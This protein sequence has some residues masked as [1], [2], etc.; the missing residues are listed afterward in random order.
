MLGC[1]EHVRPRG[2]DPDLNSWHSIEAPSCTARFGKD[3]PLQRLQAVLTGGFSYEVEAMNQQY[4]VP[5]VAERLLKFLQQ[6]DNRHALVTGVAGS[7]KTS[8]LAYVAEQLK[9]GGAVVGVISAMDEP[10]VDGL[11]ARIA[12]AL[13][14]DKS[15]AFSDVRAV[16]ASLDLRPMLQQ[17]RK[18][19]SPV[20]L[21]IDDLE[22]VQEL[23]SLASLLE[24]L[25]VEAQGVLRVVLA[26]RPI[27][28]V[29]RLQRS[30]I[31]DSFELSELGLDEAK[32]LLQRA[33]GE[34]IPPDALSQIL[35][36]AN[37]NP[38]FLQLFAEAVK[39]SGTADVVDRL[40][41]GAPA[42]QDVLLHRIFDLQNRSEAEKALLGCLAV[43]EFATPQRL[44][45]AT[46]LDAQEVDSALESLGRR[47]LVVQERSDWCFLH[48]RLFEDAPRLLFPD[49]A[50]APEL[51][52]FGAEA[53][54]QDALLESQ[55][56]APPDLSHIMSGD[57]TIVLG[58][59][60]AGKSAVFRSLGGFPT[61]GTLQVAQPPNVIVALSKDPATFLQKYSARDGGASSADRFKAL[62]LLFCAAL[63]AREVHQHLL[64]TP[65][66][67][68]YAAVAWRLLRQV[69]WASNIRGENGLHKMW[70]GAKNLLPH[71]VSFSAGPVTIEPEWS[72]SEAGAPRGGLEIDD[73]IDRTDAAL[74]EHYTRLLIVVD[75]ID[76]LHKYDRQM[77]EAMVQG[78]FLAETY[79]SQRR[80]VRL[81]VLLRTDLY[82][83]YDIQEKNK[84]VSRTVNLTWSWPQI[85]LQMLGRA[86][87][88]DKL[89]MISTRVTSL[90]VTTGT[91]DFH[92]R[93]L[94]PAAVEGK[95]ALDWLHESLRNARGD[96][97]PRQIILF[98]N[99]LKQ[100]AR[101]ERRRIPI[102]S[103]AELVAA[104][105]DV[106]ESAFE[107]V[108]NDF[109]V[110]VN[111]VRNCKSGEI[112][113]FRTKDVEKLFDTSDGP[114]NAQ[115]DLLER[116]GFI[117]RE[118][119]S[120]N[121]VAVPQ[122][123][124]PRL[125]SR[126][127]SFI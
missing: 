95:P 42:L 121:G 79:L 74:V 50:V 72:R 124:V 53:A 7:G 108:V 117:G 70:E 73:F 122:F 45:A 91:A 15:L 33:V 78:L 47:G 55:F 58:D 61:Q 36:I 106:S 84:F 123:S 56:V 26:S 65:S 43:L 5:A 34:S 101:G 92:L 90:G 16:Q 109:R 85:V 116:L 41:Q 28:V 115:I 127:W 83:V 71:K 35:G 82:E 77:Q 60:G 46:G 13:D 94:F 17:T 39:Q 38:L 103:E 14:I 120:D 11:V 125:Y 49:F 111:F 97:A 51:L 100:R 80:A 48:K 98:L 31:V 4:I 3:T 30:P 114:I 9:V 24:N 10:S 23:G 19:G 18:L 6:Q 112:S 86:F 62:W 37:G 110:A 96:V 32:A 93:L 67:K 107:E 69:G 2:N 104:M 81:I 63:A 102:F 8:L 105:R 99:F 89:R 118:V 25:L 20:F 44:R 126:C 68:R 54:E 66:G 21:F 22:A 29:S 12:R 59:R 113:V 1:I 87:A 88:N 75:Q 64:H 27:G 40:A 76:E 57:K 52:S 119:V